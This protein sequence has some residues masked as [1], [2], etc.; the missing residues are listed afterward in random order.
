[1]TSSLTDIENGIP[2]P[3][4]ILDWDDTLLASTWIINQEIILEHSIITEQHQ[5]DILEFEEIIYNFLNYVKNIA[6]VIIVTNAEEEWVNM[7]SQKFMPKVYQLFREINV[8]S[9]RKLY[10][11]EHPENPE[12]WKYKTFSNIV[13]T[14][15]S[16]NLIHNCYIDIISIGDLIVERNAVLL[17][18]ETHRTITRTKSFKL[19]EKPTITQ[20][21]NQIQLIHLFINYIIKYQNNLDLF[22]PDNYFDKN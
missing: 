15:V 10:I 12:I 21:K 14:Y 9:A 17:A 13:N 7:S 2:K 16:N 19:I 4:L 3:L 20:L 5:K 8:T 22:I 1:M 11:D 18:T 6:N